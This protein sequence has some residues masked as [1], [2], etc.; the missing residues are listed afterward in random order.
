MGSNISLAARQAAAPQSSFVLARLQ[1]L[2]QRHAFLTEGDP[3]P[4]LPEMPTT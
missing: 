3:V 1:C 4:S 2:P